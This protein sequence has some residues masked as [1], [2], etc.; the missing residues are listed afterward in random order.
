MK[1]TSGTPMQSFKVVLLSSAGVAIALILSQ[2]SMNYQFGIVL[3][4]PQLGVF[5]AA[6]AGGPVW[7]L[8]AGVAGGLGFYYGHPDTTWLIVLALMGVVSGLL[9]TRYRPTAAA[10]VSWLTVGLVSS[11]IIYSQNGQPSQAFYSWLATLS[12]EVVASAI[13]VDAA[14]TLLGVSRIKRKKAEP[15]EAAAGSEAQA[16]VGL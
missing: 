15:S 12:Y 10:L 3:A 11:Y 1:G 14:L 16:E 8:L 5:L 4:L 6:G 9:S 7:G 2:Y 13:V